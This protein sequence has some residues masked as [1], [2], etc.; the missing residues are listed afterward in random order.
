MEEIQNLKKSYQ[1]NILVDSSNARH[2][3]QKL[4]TRAGK[5]DGQNR[6]CAPT[7]LW[8]P[9]AGACIVARVSCQ[10]TCSGGGQ[11]QKQVPGLTVS[12][13]A[14]AEALAVGT[15]Y[16]GCKMV[17]Q[18][19]TRQWRTV[20]RQ[21][22]KCTAGW[23]SP[24]HTHSSRGVSCDGLGCCVALTQ[25]QRSG[26]DVSMDLVLLWGHE[27]GWGNGEEPRWPASATGIPV[28]QNH[29]NLQGVVAAILAI[30]SSVVKAD[31]PLKIRS[32][33]TM[34]AHGEKL[35]SVVLT[36][37][38]CSLAIPLCLSFAGFQVEWN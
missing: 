9:T 14:A 17:A 22:G 35:I 28:G 6:W 21:P 36:L 12:T 15:H 18:V 23:V 34:V 31:S 26:V 7:L 4:G 1:I 38:S 37:L 32:L 5:S 3:F 25:P 8:G 13:P 11:G 10:H 16:C 27:R 29:W 24:R 33:G 30:G 2:Q 20:K 19:C